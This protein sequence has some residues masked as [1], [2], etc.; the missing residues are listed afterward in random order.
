MKEL[1]NNKSRLKDIYKSYAHSFVFDSII[2]GN[3]PAQI[4]VD[5]AEDISIFLIC[6]G[7]CVYF[8]GEVEDKDK[9]KETINFFKENYLSE[10]RRKELGVVKI[11]YYTEAWEKEL[12]EG[13]N[14]FNCNLYDRS[15]FKQDLKYVK[16]VRN[17]DNVIVKRIDNEVVKNA[18]L[19]NLNC[20]I[21]EVMGMWGS[22][23]NFIK[24]GFGYCAI[25]DG[26]I[27]S[28]CTAEYVSKNYCGIGIETIEEYKTKGVATMI[29]NEFLKECLT[30]NITPY[31]DSWKRNI[32]SV[33]VAEKNNF[34]KVCDYKIVLIEFN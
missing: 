22:V 25:M 17:D 9:Y 33:R 31:W 15:L 24:S 21:D 13:L 10:S 7:H 3:T 8:G 20:L 16:A 29:S 12:L 4:F 18:P 11:N 23:D 19:G 26:N 5:D 14:E 6:E 2:E 32:P 28:W 1:I 27:I 34:Q 30:S